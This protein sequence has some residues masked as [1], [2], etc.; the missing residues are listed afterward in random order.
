MDEGVAR[1]RRRGSD[2]GRR[3]LL[4]DELGK[5]LDRT[6]AK[7]ETSF[8]LLQAGEA[9]CQVAVKLL[10]RVELGG[11]GRPLV[12]RFGEHFLPHLLHEQSQLARAPLQLGSVDLDDVAGL[13]ARQLV[14]GALDGVLEIVPV[15]DQ[16]G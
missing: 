15:A 13:L 9:T 11:V 6:F 4:G 3:R 5:G 12:I 2:Q 7:N 8:Q 16:R 10:E 14:I 1:P